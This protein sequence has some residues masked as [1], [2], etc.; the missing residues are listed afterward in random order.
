[1]QPK[2]PA[3]IKQGLVNIPGRTM[4][5]KLPAT[6]IPGL[7]NIPGRDPQAQEV[8]AS[9]LEVDRENHH[10]YFN[11]KGFHNHL[12]HHLLAA[13]DL[14]APA[15]VLQRIYEAEKNSQRPI[16]VGGEQENALDQVKIT[17][18]NFGEYVGQERYYG[19]FLTFFTEQIVELGVS[20]TLER[21]IFSTTVNVK[22]L[23]MLSR[24]LSGAD[25]MVAQGLAQ[26][27]I[28]SPLIPELFDFA[29]PGA[30]G[31]LLKTSARNVKGAVSEGKP[32]LHILRDIYDSEILKPVM[33]YDPDALL[34]ARREALMK[35]GRPEE[36]RR[37]CATWWSSKAPEEEVLGLKEKVEELFWVTA[38]LLTGSGKRGRKPRLDFFLM[39]A[40]NATLF[41]PS[42]LKIIS[43]DASK[44]KLVKGF[45]PITMMYLLLRGRPRIDA[46]LAM[47][48]SA[49]PRPPNV[50]APTLTPSQIII[51][52]PNDPS[53][54]N[55]WYNILTSVIH[56][57]DAHTVKAIRALCY[58]AQQYGHK[59]ATDVPG[60]FLDE[61]Q[62]QETL[63]GISEVDGTVFVR[64]A[65]VVM[66]TLGWVTHGDAH[67][68]WDRSGLG[69]DDAWKNED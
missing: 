28:H 26:A 43:N 56:A 53:S 49:T 24:F 7:V 59:G 68:Q 39:H 31:D 6:I 22:G 29:A 37:L 23:D 33:P 62:K 61:A 35:D 19:A 36:M 47:S 17:P 63:P 27:S 12:S 44:V 34:T 40:L 41:V 15:S 11:A 60:C 5:P 57:P 20:E 69:W 66:D 21:Y 13:Y 8:T 46:G 2:L 58:A 25:A 42:L 54:Y 50:S 10:C 32:L 16:D 30:A 9:L 38:L 1:M 14:A 65:G 18:D 52:N 3:H 64:A 67:G 48:Y 45:L 4:Q 55:P 51:G